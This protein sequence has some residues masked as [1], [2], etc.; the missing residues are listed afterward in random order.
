MMVSFN[1]SS[2]SSRSFRV[3][4]GCACLSSCVGVVGSVG[5]NNFLYYF[6]GSLL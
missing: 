4:Q 1:S 3:K 6:G 2:A 5:L